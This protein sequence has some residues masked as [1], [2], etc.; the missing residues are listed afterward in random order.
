[1]ALGSRSAQL[2]RDDSVLSICDRD[3]TMK[4]GTSSYKREHGLTIKQQ[5]ALDLLVCGETHRSVAEAIKVN[6]VTVTKWLNYDP[7]FQAALNSRRTELWGTSVDRFRSLLPLAMDALEQELHGKQRGRVALEILRLAGLD[8]A[9]P[10]T[11][12]LETYG[13]GPTDPDV[14]IDARARAQRHD[15]VD[16]LLHGDPVTDRERHAVLESLDQ[17]LAPE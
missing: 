3:V 5:N 17:L 9:G 6:R 10:K 12:S 13:V 15:P 7:H 4:S 16:D 11:S 14:I 8:R 2:S 1:M